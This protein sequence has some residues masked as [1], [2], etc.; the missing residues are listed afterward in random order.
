WGGGGG[1]VSSPIS[2]GGL[3]S[4]SNE[5]GCALVTRVQMQQ[6]RSSEKTLYHLSMNQMYGNLSL[7]TS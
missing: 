6:M 3:S 1:R 5:S 2:K 7:L 4:I